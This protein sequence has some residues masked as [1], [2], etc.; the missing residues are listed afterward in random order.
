[1]NKPSSLVTKEQPVQLPGLTQLYRTF[2]RIEFRHTGMTLRS[3]AFSPLSFSHFPFSL[4][5]PVGL[6]PSGFS[7]SMSASGV[8]V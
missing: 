7:A 5:A 2:Q 8:L 3:S 1:M 6:S 4:T